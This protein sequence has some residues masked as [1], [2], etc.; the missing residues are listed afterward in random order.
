MHHRHAVPRYLALLFCLLPSAFAATSVAPPP[1]VPVR[2]TDTAF[3]EM[4]TTFSED[5]GYFASNNWVSNET[6]YQH[7]IPRLQA[8]V[9]PGGVYVGVGPDQNFTYLV[10]LKPSLAFIVDIRRQN[11]LHHLMYKALIELS[12]TR[13]DFVSRLFGRP[14]PAGLKDDLSA[15]ALMSTFISRT[16]TAELINQTC[17]DMFDR[18]VRQHKFPLS[19]EDRSTLLTVYQAF[20]SNG[21]G[22][23][24]T[25]VPAFVTAP[26]GNDIVRMMRT[27]FPAYSDLVAMT[28]AEGLNRGYLAN[29]ANYKVLRDMQLRNAIVPVVGDF[30][31]PKALKSVA[32][33]IKSKGGR[34]TTFYTSNVE[35][36]LFQHPTKWRTYYENVAAMPLDETSMFIRSF[37]GNSGG[38]TVNIVLNDKGEPVI[39]G[40]SGT[41]TTLLDPPARQ[42]APF[43]QSWQLIC[44]V[45][46][47]LA[48]VA[49]GRLASYQDVISFSK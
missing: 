22:I 42:V 23:T 46:E 19:D 32:N 35:Q 25:G 10:A 6:V 11:L 38:P 14:R 33:Y 34:A 3:W 5:G 28:D 48:G 40:R 16:P 8:T 17:D 1:E 24:Y 4:V 2:L 29:E 41:S 18:L 36:Y 21:P 30:A 7:V 45:K 13:A 27:P 39:L 26:A 44:S 9:K 15:E 12:P 47:L 49:A 31:G 43:I 20:Y 37:F